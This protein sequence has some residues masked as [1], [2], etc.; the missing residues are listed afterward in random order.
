MRS[1][2]QIMRGL[3]PVV[4]AQ[5]ANGS[6]EKSERVLLGKTAQ[7]L[8]CFI[9]LAVLPYLIPGLNRYRVLVPSRALRLLRPQR[10]HVAASPT[11]PSPSA[12]RPATEHH[13]Q[14]KVKTES[15]PGEIE[16]PSGRS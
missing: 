10:D 14:A 15:K 6:A 9:A 12:S 1:P 8:L 16:D 13:E 5:E 7:A 2:S 11:S 3:V 4:V